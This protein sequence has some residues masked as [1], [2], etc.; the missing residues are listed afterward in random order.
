L[1]E[2]AWQAALLSIPTTDS[3]FS[4]RSE[5]I[6]SL[7]TNVCRIPE[8][9]QKISQIVC[10]T[11]GDTSDCVVEHVKNRLHQ[12]LQSILLWHEKYFGSGTADCASMRINKDRQHEA[13]GF[14]YAV[15]IILNRLLFSLDPVG[16]ASCEETAEDYASKI[17]LIEK[18]GLSTVSQAELFMAIKLGVARTTL[19]TAARW[20]N[21]FMESTQYG[22]STGS[23][24]LPSVV[25]MDWCQRMGWKTPRPVVTK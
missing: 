6:V 4:D 22:P 2:D 13:L 3:L 21:W 14:S 12:L 9:F 15:S 8:Y 16:N 7:L 10:I 5:P 19:A 20:R 18:E 23:H 17:Q 25:F 1:G 24:M 11:R